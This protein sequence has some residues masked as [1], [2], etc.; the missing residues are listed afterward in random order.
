MLGVIDG[1]VL[2]EVLVPVAVFMFGGLLHTVYKLGILTQEVKRLREDFD[3]MWQTQ[4]GSIY[5]RKESRGEHV[6]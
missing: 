5:Y 3:R 6:D 4:A 2:F 1:T